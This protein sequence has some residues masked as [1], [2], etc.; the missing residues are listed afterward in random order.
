MNRPINPA[1]PG[2]GAAGTVAADGL[3]L[4]FWAPQGRGP[5]RRGE[6][7][8]ALAGGDVDLGH[9]APINLNGD[10]HPISDRRVVSWRWLA[11]AAL[12]GAFGATLIAS[13]IYVS[14]DGQTSFAELPESAI[15]N[16]PQA[17]G[18]ETASRKG[19]KLVAQRA[20][21][22]AK[23]VVRAPMTQ[24][25]GEREVTKV[26]PFVRLAANLS[27]TT[28]VYATDV[29]PFNP[30]KLFAEGSPGSEKAGELPTDVPDADVSVVKRDLAGI[31]LGAEASPLGDTEILDQI[32]EERANAAAS[33]RRSPLPIPPQLM[34][35]RTL[36]QPG[37]ASTDPLSYAPVDQPRFSGIEVRVVPE[38]VTVLAKT[39]TPATSEPMVDEKTLVVKRGETLEQV[40]RAASATTEQFRSI[41]TALGAKAKTVEGQVLQVMIA[42][43]PRPGDGRQIVRVALLHEGKV[44]AIA[45]VTDRAVFVPVAPPR[46]EETPRKN[47][48]GEDEDEDGENEP[49]SGPRLYDSLYETAMRHDMPR[50]L[51]DEMVRVF[52]SDVDFQRRVSGGDT[53]E[54]IY[55]DADEGEGSRSE[56]L[57]ATLTVGGESRRVYRFQSQD[58]G[59]IDFFDE[60]GRSLK[61]FLLRKPITDGEM[62][63]GFGMRYHP[64][65]RYSKM[66]A[67]VDWANRV[68]TPI[69][70]AGN[71]TIALADWSSGYGRRVEIQ[72][73]NGYM[74]TYS[75]MS[76]FARGIQEGA[77]VRQGQLIGYL[78]SSGLSTGP[79]LHYEVMVNGNFVNPIRIK[80]PR[81]REL[82]GRALAEFKRQRDEIDGLIVRA[83]GSK[84]TQ[85][86]ALR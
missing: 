32:E 71:G 76:G 63:S 23:Q 11:A 64:I 8:P 83:G 17:G 43:G 7:G 65:L 24:R 12:V 45:A 47:S 80:V 46:D 70:A 13:A 48:R 2:F 14:H 72:H 82:D 19:D 69:L 36:R 34:L 54:V 62:R 20:S 27:L 50:A 60:A 35:G 58:D 31:P 85:T 9:D 44:D 74:T 55:T 61:K 25:I 26:R 59:V 37:N 1:A 5:L 6:A 38:N 15:R 79:H 10:D 53:L 33:G 51:I 75:H 68:G 21:I 52:A 30:L 78:G 84:I 4:P 40:L 66:H 41:Q 28:G 81:G 73:A 56:I 29:P 3:Q 18:P 77:R 42:P 39:P 67:G 57:S 86:S 22:A 16:T 49:E